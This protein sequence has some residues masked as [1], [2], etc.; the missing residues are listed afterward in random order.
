M[1]G[2]REE[3]YSTS[4]LFKLKC[5]YHKTYKTIINKQSWSKKGGRV[6]LSK[7]M[8]KL[9]AK[10]IENNKLKYFLWPAILIPIFIGIIP[11]FTGLG[12]SFTSWRLAFR[13]IQFIGIQNY[14]SMFQNP[15]FWSAIRVTVIFSGLALF[16][17]ML[18]GF[19]I[20]WLLSINLKG[21][22]FFRSVILVPLMVAP[23]LSALMWK[24]MLP[25]HGVINYLLSF[26]GI[27]GVSWLANPSTALYSVVFVD[28]YIYIPFVAIIILAGFQSLPKE[29][30][31]AAA[32]DGAGKLFVFRRITL[33]L[34]TPLILLAFIFRFILSLKTFDILY[35][36]TGGGPGNVTTNL[37]LF[38]YLNTFKYGRGA[39]S[40]SAV[41]LLFLFIFFVSKYLIV[42][43][44]K[45][46]QYQ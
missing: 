24:L 22:S 15:D 13:N 6:S 29:P 9:S 1:G 35:A 28:C 20:G 37:H 2:A 43:W 30:Y 8:N 27:E 42:R 25:Q 46:T 44:T 31:E 45:S 18:F 14:I 5:F 32:V 4:L 7:E 23:V 33:P 10:Q 3:K 21:Q 17:E 19:L 39:I 26:L 34:L 41:L 11:F 40:T 36:T 38:A 12:L 16:F